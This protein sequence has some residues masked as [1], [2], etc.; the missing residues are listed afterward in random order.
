MEII[1]STGSEYK[2]NVGVKATE[3]TDIKLVQMDLDLPEIQETDVEKIATQS[4]LFA[5]AEIGKPVIVTDVGYYIT[6]LNGFPGPYIKYINKWLTP[7]DLLRLM[8]GI[9]NREIIVRECMAYAEP[10]KE[11][12]L[13]TSEIKDSLSK[14]KGGG[15]GST[16]D[17]IYIPTGYT[18]TAS[19]IE[20]E[21]MYSYWSSNHTYWKRLVEYIQRGG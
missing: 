13:F 17:Y 10:G 1:F 18:M 14:V 5:L 4:A 21:E 6:A 16:I 3:N 11:V 19:E 7:E 20:M 12:K 8:D 9:E 2:F 15:T